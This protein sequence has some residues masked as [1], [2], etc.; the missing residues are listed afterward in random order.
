M[1]NRKHNQKPIPFEKGIKN[2]FNL[3]P[4][5]FIVSTFWHFVFLYDNI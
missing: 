1:K 3:F 5:I 2:Q 4:H